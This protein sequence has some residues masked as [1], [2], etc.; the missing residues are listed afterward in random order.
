[1]ITPSSAVNIVP[2]AASSKM[3]Q[4]GAGVPPGGSRRD[5]GTFPPFGLG[6]FVVV[7]FLVELRGRLAPLFG[8]FG[9]AMRRLLAPVMVFSALVSCTPEP[10]PTPPRPPDVYAVAWRSLVRDRP[11]VMAYVGKPV[12]FRVERTDARVEGRTLRLWYG[13]P[14]TPP[15]LIVD[16]TDPIVGDG[17]WIIT[18]VVAPLVEDGAK[19]GMSIDYGVLVSGARVTV[20]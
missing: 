1:V 19:R 8:R 10:P 12:R 4:H 18:G 11:T 9:P 2:L 5:V 15:V 17:P 6:L 7:F 20:P 14:S 16:C 13:N 3:V